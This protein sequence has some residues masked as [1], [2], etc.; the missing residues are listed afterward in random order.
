MPIEGTAPEAG[1]PY[2]RPG[3]IDR[4]ESDRIDA[5][6]KLDDPSIQDKAAVHKQLR[7]L[8]LQLASQRP[9]TITG[10]DK[11][12]YVALEQELRKEMTVGMP[13]HEELRKNPPGAVAKLARWQKAKCGQFNLTNKSAMLLWK[14]VRLSLNPGET[15]IA[16]FEQYRPRRSTLSMDNAQIQGQQFFLPPQQNTLEGINHG[17]R[18][19]IIF[20]D[21]SEKLVAEAALVALNFW[22]GK[23]GAEEPTSTQA[24]ALSSFM[25]EDDG[26]PSVYGPVS[27]PEETPAAD[28]SAEA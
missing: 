23:D 8:D 3:Q 25:G 5:V 11:D 12:Q 14:N 21:E 10:K 18:H 19:Q 24:E 7:R 13:S 26:R 1:V 17:I 16:N 27:T 20:G 4:M 22:M 6:G 9:A 15:D 2:L 28:A